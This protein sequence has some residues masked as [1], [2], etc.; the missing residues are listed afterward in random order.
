MPGRF[1][2]TVHIECWELDS[3]R[4]WCVRRE[5]LGRGSAY[6]SKLARYIH[7]PDWGTGAWWSQI[8]GSHGHVKQ[9]GDYPRIADF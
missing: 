3:E 7:G 9:S 4:L 2:V 5:G 8:S 1:L 6:F